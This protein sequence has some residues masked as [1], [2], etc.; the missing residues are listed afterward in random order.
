MT[1]G[2][3][4]DLREERAQIFSASSASHTSFSPSCEE[5]MRGGCSVP[6]QL[7]LWQ[8]EAVV[9]VGSLGWGRVR[10]GR[11]AASWS[12]AGWGFDPSIGGCCQR[13]TRLWFRH[14]GCLMA[15]VGLPD[16]HC[17]SA[18][19]KLGFSLWEG[20]EAQGHKR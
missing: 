17:N 14:C 1:R 11:G 6:S 2:R 13:F 18:R 9:P 12:A 8:N 5:V 15:C 19:W 4:P 20:E 16:P 3:A 7:S 10:V